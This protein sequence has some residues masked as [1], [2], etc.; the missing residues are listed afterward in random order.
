M[1]CHV[2]Q[3]CG[4]AG[5]GESVRREYRQQTGRAAAAETVQHDRQHPAL[6]EE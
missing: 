6:T 1:I 5:A 2:R 3:K 4:L